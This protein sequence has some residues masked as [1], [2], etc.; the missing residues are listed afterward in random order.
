MSNVKHLVNLCDLVRQNNIESIRTYLE[1]NPNI[2]FKDSS[3]IFR[4]LYTALTNKYFPIAELLLEHGADIDETS[5]RTDSIMTGLNYAIMSRDIELIKFCI[6]HGS[7]INAGNSALIDACTDCFGNDF[8]VIKFLLANGANINSANYKYQTPLIATII[9]GRNIELAYFLI[10][11]GAGLPSDEFINSLVDNYGKRCIKI[12]KFLKFYKLM[13]TLYT[14]D[15]IGVSLNPDNIDMI[16]DFL[17][18]R[19]VYDDKPTPNEIIWQ[20]YLQSY[21]SSQ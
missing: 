9:S 13:E 8:E 17:Q 5:G 12:Q 7:N 6:E 21:K 10:T 14:F 3:C 18:E 2:N 19:I 1:S 4:P 16:Q 11:N 20:K 15:Y